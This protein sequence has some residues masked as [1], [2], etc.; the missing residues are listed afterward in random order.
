MPTMNKHDC[1]GK[2]LELEQIEFTTLVNHLINS[3]S[4]EPNDLTK[5][6]FEE[7]AKFKV[8]D[9]ESS[10][11]AVVLV[12]PR[13]PTSSLPAVED[14]IIVWTEK[15]QRQ[16]QKPYRQCVMKIDGLHYYLDKNEEIKSPVTVYFPTDV[17]AAANSLRV[18][19]NAIAGH[20]P[21]ASLDDAPFKTMLEKV[22]K[23]YDTL[24]VEI[25]E[26][27]RK[28]LMEEFEKIKGGMSIFW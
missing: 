11:K 9:S 5:C 8:P 22:K 20:P 16:H 25:P 13:E 12:A 19:R 21:T 24:M 15:R 3:E 10:K 4:H 17:C 28:R 27:D 2:P 18:M 14:A 26:D 7:S 6:D 23:A 1:Q